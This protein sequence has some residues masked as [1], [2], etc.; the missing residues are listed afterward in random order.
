MKDFLTRNSEIIQKYREKFLFATSERAP[1]KLKDF[2]GKCVVYAIENVVT[3]KVY[4]GKTTNLLNRV[5]HYIWLYRN[6]DNSKYDEKRP[7]A[8]AMKTEGI[9]N[10]IMYPVAIAP[11]RDALAVTE[12]GIILTMKKYSPDR[13]Y[14][15]QV[16][17]GTDE[18]KYAVHGTFSQSASTKTA[19]SKVIIA[20]NPEIKKAYISIGLK[21]FGDFVG[22]SKDQVKNCAKRGIRHRGYYI[23]YL[24]TDDRESVESK[25][26]TN[27]E[28]ILKPFLEKRP[29][30]HND[31]Y[32]EY[33]YFVNLVDTMMEEKSEKCFRDLGYE[34][35][36][37]AYS[38]DSN[39]TM[40]YSLRNIKDFFDM[41][42]ATESTED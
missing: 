38:H 42:T 23:I 11:D 2:K 16:P 28:E 41:L 30:Y 37:I 25:R 5:N 1:I 22:S 32:E 9:E 24:N 39:P 10:F 13:L 15:T 19:K 36:F 8:D 21:L 12:M 7:I 29:N 40:S 20:I 4:I 6:G 17:C 14:N 31:K 18:T 26:K 3:K 33:F 34:C 35:G 27:Q